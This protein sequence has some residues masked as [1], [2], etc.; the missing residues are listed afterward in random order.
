MATCY[1]CLCDAGRTKWRML[2]AT[3]GIATCHRCWGN[4]IHEDHALLDGGLFHRWCYQEGVNQLTI[5]MKVVFQ[6]N[7]S[8]TPS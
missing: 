5:A 4:I 1:A 6:Y 2:M 3:N 8:V 7:P